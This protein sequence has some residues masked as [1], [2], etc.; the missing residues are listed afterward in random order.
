VRTTYLQY[1]KNSLKSNKRVDI[2]ICLSYMNFLVEVY[3][4]KLLSISEIIRLKNQLSMSILEDVQLHAVF[5]KATAFFL[6]KEK[7]MQQK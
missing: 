3:K 5:G 7:T 4:N 1:I 2:G 6:K